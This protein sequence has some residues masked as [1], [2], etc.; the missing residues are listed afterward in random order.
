MFAGTPQKEKA[1]ALLFQWVVSLSIVHI[2]SVEYTRCSLQFSLSM[3]QL[4]YPKLTLIRPHLTAANI[5]LT[6]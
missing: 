4:L 2:L 1:A 6:P 3:P 5:F